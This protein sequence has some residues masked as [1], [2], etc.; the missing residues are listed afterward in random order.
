M[1]RTS[2]VC[3]G[4]ESGTGYRDAVEE[5]PVIKPGDFVR[6]LP[7]FGAWIQKCTNSKTTRYSARAHSLHH[8]RFKDTTSR[9]FAKLASN[10]KLLSNI[11]VLDDIGKTKIHCALSVI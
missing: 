11:V 4:P 7:W 10:K 2:T 1:G 6:K 8:C 5:P 3:R 9:I